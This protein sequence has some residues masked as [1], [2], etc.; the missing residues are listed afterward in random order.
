MIDT[1]HLSRRR[2][3]GLAAVG[4]AGLMFGCGSNSE[5]DVLPGLPGPE[6]SGI[7]HSIMTGN[8]DSFEGMM[9]IVSGAVPTDLDG[10]AFVIGAVP[11]EDGTPI[12]NGDGKIYRFSPKNGG[13]EVKARMVE[14]DCYKVDQ[15]VGNDPEMGFGSS[16]FARI[17]N[18]FGYRNFGNT[19]FLPIQ[20]HRLLATYDAGRPWEIDPKTLEV[21]TPVGYLDAW[22][23][24]LPSFTPAMNFFTLCMTSAHPAYDAQE[25]MTYMVNFAA[26]MPGINIEP[27]V[28][29]LWWD[30]TSEPKVVEIVGQ[31]D[32][33]LHIEMSCHQ[34]F[35]TQNHVVLLDTALSVEAEQIAG[36]D[37][38]RGQRP[39]SRFIIIPKSELVDGGKA[40]AI[41]AVVDREA[42]HCEAIYD[43]SDGLI[44]VMLPHMNSADASEWIR[45]DD[46]IFSTGKP[47]DPA[48][49]GLFTYPTD[50]S[51][52]GHYTIDAASG[53]LVASKLRSDE[54]TWGPGLWTGDYRHTSTT[55]L[56]HGYWATIGHMPDLITS[57]VAELYRDHP[58]REV[59]LD[60]LPTEE[61]APRIMRID[62]NT[63]DI[64]D[65]YELD[66]GHLPMSPTFV[67]KIDGD[68][69]E[70]YLLSTTLT[71]DGDE[72]WIYD[73]TQIGNGPI[74]RLRHDKLVMPFTFHT[75]WMPELKQQVSP[76]Y[77]TDPQLDYGTRLADLSASAQSVITQVL[78]VTI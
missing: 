57:R 58:F 45:P 10:H 72:L 76:A 61:I 32:E 38:S 49:H 19:A 25:E 3:L 75:T 77:Q 52:F 53:E 46:T 20:D 7:P 18:A 47:V 15:A 54:H 55:E 29:V 31:D 36:G 50:R 63:L 78:P 22:H 14:T 39:I 21:L 40:K 64:V 59:P 42:L 74:C 2:F 17:S 41:E 44:R 60:D 30:G 9:D 1:K 12:F 70:G 69:D 68:I 23:P 24:M 13:L 4:G 33:P 43:D 16:V 26:P 73:T 34:M 62:H 67:P 35:V 65:Y 5:P 48:Y 66:K 8:R 6:V 56:G 71:P 11:Y 28:R 27:F 37:A 51:V